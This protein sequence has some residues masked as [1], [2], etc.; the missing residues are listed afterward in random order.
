M[1]KLHGSRSETF[2]YETIDSLTE[3]GEVLKQIRERLISEGYTIID[4]K[5]SKKLD[6]IKF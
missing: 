4:G 1:N 3:L 6:T 5:I 2:T